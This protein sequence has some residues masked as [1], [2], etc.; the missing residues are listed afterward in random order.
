MTFYR[1]NIPAV[2]AISLLVLALASCVVPNEGEETVTGS[3]GL[4][5]EFMQEAMVDEVYEGDPYYL[6]LYLMNEGASDIEDGT[7]QVSINPAGTFT[8]ENKDEFSTFSLRGDDGYYQGE[9]KVVEIMMQSEEITMEGVEGQQSSIKVNACYEYETFFQDTLC[10]DTDIRQMKAAKPCTPRDLIGSR[11][12]GAP[13]VVERI[14]P[15]FTSGTSGVRFTFE[16]TLRNAG[17]G[18]VLAPQASEG[19]CTGRFHAE[20]F[21][22]VRIEEIKMSSYSL[23]EGDFICTSHTSNPNEYELRN[24]RQ[25]GVVCRLRDDISSSLGTFTTPMTITLSYGYLESLETEVQINTIE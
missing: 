1:K 21:G 24:D 3:R 10:V 20:D 5:M 14:S 8:L 2:A 22:I 19:I 6:Q 7:I 18:T 23:S 25:D 17:S 12:Q 16:M 9:E 4:V 13:V 15:T 11:G